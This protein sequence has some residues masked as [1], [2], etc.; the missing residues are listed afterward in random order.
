M[1]H[2]F[3]EAPRS[4]DPHHVDDMASGVS[5]VETVVDFLSEQGNLGEAVKLLEKTKGP[6]GL[7]V[8]GLATAPFTVASGLHELSESRKHQGAEKLLD[9]IGGVAELAD[10]ALSALPF[11]GRESHA[12]L[13]V[14]EFSEVFKTERAG[15]DAMRGLVGKDEQGHDMSFTDAS[16]ERAARLDHATRHAVYQFAHKRLG[17]PNRASDLVSSGAGTAVG[18]AESAKNVAA[19][20]LPL[21]AMGVWS[22]AKSALGIGGEEHHEHAPAVGTGG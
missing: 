21:A 3:Q 22:R 11:F 15:D 1:G 12:G 13:A 17:L 2:A 6:S 20:W 10:G 18:M 7:D 5:T 4:S 19:G 8:L 9:Q 16:A 14:K